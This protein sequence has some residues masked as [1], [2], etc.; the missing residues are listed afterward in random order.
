[1]ESIFQG[2]CDR[3][4][5]RSSD[6]NAEEGSDSSKP[7]AKRG[8]AQKKIKE[9]GKFSLAKKCRSGTTIYHAIH[10]DITTIYHH[11]TPRKRQTPLQKRLSTTKTFFL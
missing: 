2:G 5:V 1:M 9:R 6:Y 4:S 7:R 8:R 10:H 3:N 11:Q